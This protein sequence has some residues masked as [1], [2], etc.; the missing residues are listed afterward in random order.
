MKIRSVV[1]LVGLVIGFTVPTFAQ[2]KDT[3]VDP[4]LTEQL[5]ALNKKF[6]DAYNNNDG[7]MVWRTGEWSLTWQGKTGDP[8][9]L[10]GYWTCIE[11]LDAGGVRKDKVQTW[12]IVA[13]PATTKTAAAETK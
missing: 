12:N 4:R 8:L 6:D 10:K 2:Q 5:N 3:P 1:A 7:K 13:T 9:P 11:V